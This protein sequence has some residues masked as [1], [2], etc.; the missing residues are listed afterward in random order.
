L[1]PRAIARAPGRPCAHNSALKPAGSL[2]QVHRDVG[3]AQAV[4]VSFEEGRLAS[5]RPSRAAFPAATWVLAPASPVPGRRRGENCKCD[6]LVHGFSLRSEG[7]HGNDEQLTAFIDNVKTR[8]APTKQVSSYPVPP[9]RRPFALPASGRSGRAARTGDLVQA[10]IEQ[11]LQSQLVASLRPGQEAAGTTDWISPS[12]S[13]SRPSRKQPEHST[14][15]AGRETRRRAPVD[16]EDREHSAVPPLKRTRPCSLLSS[17]GE[18]PA[19]PGW[20]HEHAEAESP[21]RLETIDRDPTVRC[22][23]CALL[24]RRVRGVMGQ[25]GRAI[26]LPGGARPPVGFASAPAERGSGITRCVAPPGFAGCGGVA[27][28]RGFA[29]VPRAPRSRAPLC[30]CRDPGGTPSARVAAAWSAQWLAG[31]ASAVI[32]TTTRAAPPPSRRARLFAARPSGDPPPFPRACHPWLSPSPVKRRAP[33]S[34]A[35]HVETLLAAGAATA[36]DAGGFSRNRRTVP[37]GSCATIPG[38]QRQAN[39]FSAKSVR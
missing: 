34:A 28:G 5:S 33:P 32:P 15:G 30:E 2:N 14:Q 38:E 25:P 36:C 7:R 16:A 18:R 37:R 39:C 24:R 27:S 26:S 23:R 11:D 6:Q 21:A 10:G 1:A 3:R 12:A 29:A 4:S 17:G 35:A 31:C 13:L 20:R 9:Q 22:S 19:R 8:S